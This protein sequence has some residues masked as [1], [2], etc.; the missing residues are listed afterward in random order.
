MGNTFVKTEPPKHVATLKQEI[1]MRGWPTALSSRGIQIDHI[2]EMNDNSRR[3]TGTGT[4]EDDV[5]FDG[6]V[7]VMYHVDISSPTKGA[8]SVTGGIQDGVLVITIDTDVI[9]PAQEEM[10]MVVDT[11][12]QVGGEEP[13][14]FCMILECSKED[15]ISV[16]SFI[17]ESTNT[18]K[19]GDS[20][21]AKTTGEAKK[22]TTIQKKVLFVFQKRK[23][24][25][26]AEISSEDTR[27][28]QFFWAYQV[29]VEDVEEGVSRKRLLEANQPVLLI[30]KENEK[31]EKEDEDEDGNVEG[32]NSGYAE[33][34]FLGKPGI[35]RLKYWDIRVMERER[36][37]KK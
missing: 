26:V 18:F 5:G 16:N 33:L 36:N 1:E 4:I 2:H 25:T 32:E 22:S 30:K 31:E 17:T 11:V 29:H 23:K 28:I 13:Q 9:V 34:I 35:E 27:T 8:T 14:N 3:G 19:D 24:C 10:V 15:S 6:D 21:T 7:R 37:K 20:D 12:M